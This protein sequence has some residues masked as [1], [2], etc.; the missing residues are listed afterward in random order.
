MN[1]FNFLPVMKALLNFALVVFFASSSFAQETKPEPAENRE[2]AKPAEEVTVVM[3]TSMGDIHIELDSENAP[4]TVANFLK[5]VDDSFYDG[6]IF[7]RVINGFMIQGG[8]FKI[9]AEGGTFNK[10]KTNPPVKNESAK[11]PPNKRGTIAMARTPD[12][13][14]ATSQFF[15]NVID[16]AGLNYPKNGGGYATFGKVTKGMD[17]V[18][19]IKVVKTGSKNGMRDVPVETVTIKS[20]NRAK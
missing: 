17:V 9:N 1:L 4:K 6:T 5:Y 13:D 11:T 15:I 18:D 8:G 12:P 3:A 20:V 2:T 14:S 7:H 10:L 16:N 19:K